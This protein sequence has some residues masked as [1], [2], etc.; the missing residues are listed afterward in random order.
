MAKQVILSPH[1]D[2]AVFSCWHLINQPHSEVI[3]LFG[4]IPPEK[5]SSLWD[6]LCGESNSVRMMRV[7][8]KENQAALDSTPAS[9]LSLNYL[10]NQYRTG[11]LD[12]AEIANNILS[13]VSPETHF[14]APLAGS[15]LWR[16][17]DHIIV[18][19]VGKFLLGQGKKVSFYADVPYM[20][21][22]SRV[23]ESYKKQLAKRFHNLFGAK[24]SVEIYG[25]SK[26]EQSSKLE[27]MMKYQSQYKMTNLVSLG[28]L[29]RKANLE[30]EVLFSSFD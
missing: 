15:K 12:I 1:F 13:L 29:R 17:P 21:M 4:G 23:S 11:K 3:T 5:T 14:F 22:P 7:R 25:L 8:T 28:T 10:D 27:A 9:Y 30:R 24:P 18:R 19:E 2:D 6:K 26:E 16:H 20:Q